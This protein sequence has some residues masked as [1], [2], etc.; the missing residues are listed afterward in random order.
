[1]WL[2]LGLMS[3][4]LLGCYDILQKV[5]LQENAVIPV[6]FFSALTGALIFIPLLILSKINPDASRFFWYIPDVTF[7]SHLFFMLKSFI[8]GS[9]WIL[10]Y[11]AI[12][13]L[14][15]TI[16]SPIRSSAPLWTLLGAIIIFGERLNTWQWI[17]LSTTILFYYLFSLAGLKEGI[18][19]RKN[20]WALFMTFA[21]IIGSISSLYDKFLV[22]HFNRMAMQAWYE[23][24][25]VPYIG[26]VL[27]LFWVPGRQKTTLFK[28]KHT[29]PFIAVVLTLS[30]F[31]YFRGLAYPGALISIM[32][33]LRR[34]S[35]IISFIMGAILFHEKNI[36]L[37]AFILLGI[38]AG[39]CLIMFK[40]N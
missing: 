2:V 25:M 3:A 29:I 21:T 11:F 34:G 17:G 28:W 27:L 24:Y 35:V 30:D 31:L 38:L 10:A 19:F 4:A 14:P 6:L 16:V 12:K 23:I 20:K 37:K 1:M 40:G 26:I 22:L 7:Q 15:L 36:K 8:V 39:I 9:Q 33:T 13:N 32:T 5:S 18:S